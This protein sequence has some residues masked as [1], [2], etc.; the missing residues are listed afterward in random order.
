MEDKDE[1]DKEKKEVHS[2]YNNKKLIETQDRNE[3]T[4]RRNE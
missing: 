4:N 3:Y 2:W 1:D